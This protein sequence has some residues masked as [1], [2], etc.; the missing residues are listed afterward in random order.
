MVKKLKCLT[1]YFGL[2]IKNYILLFIFLVLLS[3]ISKIILLIPPFINGEIIDFVITAE[4]SRIV[5]LIFLSLIILLLEAFFSLLQTYLGIYLSNHT[6]IDIKEKLFR[7]IIYLRMDEYDKK[8]SGEYLSRLEG[9]AETVSSFYIKTIPNMLL[10]IITMIVTGFFSVYLSPLLTFVGLIS[11][12][13]SLMINYLFGKKVRTSFLE[14]RKATDDYSSVSQQIIIAERAVKRLHIEC[15]VLEYFTEKVSILTK[16]SIKSGMI[17]A[18]GGLLQMI[19]STILELLIMSLACYSIIKGNLSIGSYVAFNVYLAQFLTSI[20][21]MA[22][23]N[24][25]I[26]AV[27]ISMARID[28]IM[29]SIQEQLIES[30]KTCHLQGDIIIDNVEFSYKENLK[31]LDKVNLKF[32]SN[33]ITAIVGTSGCG[34]TTLLNLVMGIYEPQR[35]KIFISGQEIGTL[36]LHDLRSNISYVQQ[37]PFFIS[38]TIRNNLLLANQTAT[39]KEIEEACKMAHIYEMIMSL[40]QGFETVI[41]EQGN[42]FSSGQ[43]Q[44]LAIARGILKKAKIFLFDEITSDLDGETEKYILKTLFWL[45]KEH[46]VIIVAHRITTV[47]NIPRIIV[48]DKGRNVQ[49]GKHQ[50]LLDHCKEYQKLFKNTEE[51]RT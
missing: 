21:E 30:D 22:S 8:R 19:T 51:I 45:S 23:M 14:V 26:Q 33:T 39:D 29:T 9:D 31:V 46:T 17:S 10:N 48:F 13:I 20:R 18:Y 34:K 47:E 42:N 4:F 3:V 32:D 15:S 40:P 37:D 16:T 41:E 6:L 25:D 1:K 35:G 27:L 36:R 24:L 44:R 28:E 5:Y 11:F 43:K 49:E 2:L 38:D 7:K 12:P 50:E